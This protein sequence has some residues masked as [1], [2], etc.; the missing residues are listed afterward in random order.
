M[1]L[2]LVRATYESVIFLDGHDIDFLNG[3]GSVTVDDSL[4]GYGNIT[5]YDSITGS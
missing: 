1:A 5:G 4:S 3:D 2:V